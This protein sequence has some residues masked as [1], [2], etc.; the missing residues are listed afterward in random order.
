MENKQAIIDKIQKLFAI[1]KGS[2]N[3]KTDSAEIANE[4]LAAMMMARKL[5]AKHHIDESDLQQ[6][7]IEQNFVYVPPS[8]GM[9]FI[10]NPYKRANARGLNQ[11]RIWFE[12]LADIVAE[13]NY[14]KIGLQPEKGAVTFYG[15]EMDRD[16]AL[17]TFEKLAEIVDAFCKLEMKKAKTGAGATN[18]RTGEKVPDWKDDDIFIESFHQGF[19][20]VIK[21]M[22]SD[23]DGNGKQS[24][25]VTSYWLDN[26]SYYERSEEV[27]G[28]DKYSSDAIEIEEYYVDL[29]KKIGEKAASKLKL[30]EGI[31]NI[32]ALIQTHQVKKQE[33]EQKRLS[34]LY[35]RLG[36]DETLPPEV[37]IGL[38]SSGSMGYA[39]KMEQAKSGALSYAK[40]VSVK[41]YKVGLI[42]FGAGNERFLAPSAEINGEFTGVVSELSA[43]GSTPMHTAIEK[44][45]EHFKTTKARR[46]LMLVT[47]GF[48][49]SK[50]K[51]L[52]IAKIAKENYGVVIQCIGTDD[53]PKDF[54]DQLSSS[55]KGL[56]VGNNSLGE[57]IR[58]MAGLLGA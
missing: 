9:S 4:A 23:D 13:G 18:F 51:A 54:L 27:W 58:K 45:I 40:D 48:P 56:Q 8:Y 55:G 37:F 52:E 39:S 43:Y 46:F 36:I 25:G 50:E 19:R 15:L 14:C 3:S 2:T 47:D 29:G 35:K 53:A 57:G 28:R 31:E 12:K 10:T 17:F 1:A 26:C 38:D 44:A 49:D 33:K 41:G 7:S 34:D 11:R 16:V 24:E 20:E 21:E 32:A 42:T 22:L 30:E 5:L 6:T